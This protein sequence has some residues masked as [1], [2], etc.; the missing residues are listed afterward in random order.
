M[1][2]RSDSS[3]LHERLIVVQPPCCTVPVSCETLSTM[4]HLDVALGK[5]TESSALP[6]AL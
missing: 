6:A 5:G 3:L 2:L 1:I 4:H